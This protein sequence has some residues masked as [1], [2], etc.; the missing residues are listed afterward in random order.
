MKCFRVFCLIAV[1]LFCGSVASHAQDFHVQVLDPNVCTANPSLCTVVDT[2]ATFPVTFTADTCTFAGVPGLPMDPTTFGCL[3]VV[4]ATTSNF[5][6]LGMTFTGLDSLTFDCPTTTPG[7]LFTNSTCGSSGGVDSFFFSGGAG[8]A[9]TKE[10]VI[11]ENG[12]NPNLFDG[13]GEVN[14]VPEPGSILLLM[15]GA[16]MSGLYL[17]QDRRLLAFLKK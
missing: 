16:M 2:S 5:T 12:V 15:T 14:E 9:P 1:V 17:T 13:T 3:I 8:L 6:N 10:L 4:N 7:S 11:Y